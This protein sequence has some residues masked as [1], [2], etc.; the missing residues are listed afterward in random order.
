MNS[1][2]AYMAMVSSQPRKVADFYSQ[3]FGMWELGHSDEGDISVTD[4]HVN[5]S[6]FKQRPG[7]EGAGGR[8]GLSHFGVAVED[9]HEI[10]ALLEEHA[11]NADIQQEKGDLH[12]GEYRVFDPNGIPVSIST[13]NFGVTGKPLTV[14][15]IRHITLSVPNGN[16]VLDFFTTIFG[17]R[18]IRTSKIRREQQHPARFAGDGEINLAI[19][20]PMDGQVH[21]QGPQA[22]REV[23]SDPKE[24]AINQK[25]GLNHFGFVVSDMDALMASL[26]DELKQVTNKR[27][28]VRDM[29]EFRIFD[30]DLNAIDLSQTKGF[31]VD[32]DVWERAAGRVA[33]RG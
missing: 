16:E 28:N 21:G 22:V 4:G 13:R 30:P 18:E 29:A 26:P 20:A 3:Y 14:P 10:E 9:I 19:L 23:Y 25:R 24:A 12:H 15:R 6:I 32:F 8:T 33:G 7:V 2:L 27:P 5:V 1:H 11:P 31:E 17:F